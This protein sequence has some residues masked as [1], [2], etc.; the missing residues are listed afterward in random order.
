MKLL[1]VLL[2]AVGLGTLAFAASSKFAA[3]SHQDLVAAIA[4]KKV[5]LL[6]VNG[7]ESFQ[8]GR[9]PGAIDFTAQEKK[10]AALL[11]KDKNAL[12]VAYCGN[13][14]CGAY[15]AAAAAAKELG[16]TNVKHYAP[17]IDGWKKS[18]AKIEKS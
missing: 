13:E 8:E 4:A 7:T 14:Y 9:I 2:L 11:P 3:I 10:L 1:S 6:D 12:I 15:M 5:T 17:G 16:Y 18:G